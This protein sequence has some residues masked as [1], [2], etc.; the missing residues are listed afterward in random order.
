MQH[1]FIHYLMRELG[2]PEGERA[3]D[4]AQAIYAV[5]SVMP[6]GNGSR[7]GQLEVLCEGLWAA[8]EGPLAEERIL[9]SLLRPRSDSLLSVYCSTA[10]RLQRDLL[11]R[12][13]PHIQGWVWI[14]V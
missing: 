6:W 5:L 1:S 8:R 2:A 10:L 4:W 14:L 12:A 11:L 13:A 3:A 9:S 7:G